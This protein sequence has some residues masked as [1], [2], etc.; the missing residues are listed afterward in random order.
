MFYSLNQNLVLME[1]TL[2]RRKFS[3]VLLAMIFVASIES[4]GDFDLG[5]HLALG[6]LISLTG[7]IPRVEP[8]SY[9]L[10]N[11]E[12][13][14]H[15][16]L[17]DVL[18][19][20]LHEILG[21]WG[22]ASWYMLVASVGTW[23]L[24][25]SRNKE[26]IE[27]VRWDLILMSMGLQWLVI[28]FLGLRTHLYSYLGLSILVWFF[29]R[30]L[31]K[32]Y[33]PIVFMFWSNLHAGFLL[34]LVAMMAGSMIDILRR[35]IV[36]VKILGML[37]LELG[38]VFASTLI[39]PYG[40]GIYKQAFSLAGAGQV[41]SLNT[42]WLPLLSTSLPSESVSL[43][44]GLVLLSV[45]FLVL[46]KGKKLEK[47]GLLVSLLLSLYSLRFVL[48]L[49]VSVVLMTSDWLK[50][51]KSKLESQTLGLKFGLLAFCLVF[52]GLWGEAGTTLSSEEEFAQAHNYPIKGL[53]YLYQ[54]N[55]AD[56]HLI[57]EYDWGGYLDWKL[58]DAKVFIDG[59]MD[60][61]RYENQEFIGVYSQIVE[62]L[63]L[64]TD[65]FG[66]EM[67][68]LKPNSKLRSVLEGKGWRLLYEDVTVVVL[69][70]E[71]S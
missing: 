28:A 69:S 30:D 27:S 8:F 26:K 68:I 9:F 17:S 14:A 13:I 39:N 53:E 58:P 23:L 34:G 19:F 48:V 65:V 16:W 2:S 24:V 49:L 6:R 63:R 29:A 44:L 41:R 61:Y 64:E 35:K 37:A 1:E 57:N 56:K 5:W 25:L 52:V 55:L 47:L 15:S 12:F 42:D 31:N 67:A 59:R 7:E 20:R 43:R 62:G 50:S 70:K 45:S 3:V 21:L 60:H 33:L 18:I 10:P 54:N 71:L 4:L 32:K 46:V 51:V 40:L 36:D 11:H 66:G 38:L 22:V